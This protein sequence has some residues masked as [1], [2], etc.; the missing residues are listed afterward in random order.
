[1]SRSADGAHWQAEREADKSHG[2][3]L[4]SN[5]IRAHGLDPV[6]IEGAHPTVMP[7]LRTGCT[8]CALTSQCMR[9]LKEGTVTTAGAAFCLNA[10]VLEALAEYERIAR[11]AP[12]ISNSTDRK[13]G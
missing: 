11:T 13:V 9:S 8:L 3:A 4:L 1:M 5:M 12:P 10:P 6:E 2:I 7:A